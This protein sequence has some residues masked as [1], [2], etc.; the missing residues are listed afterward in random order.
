MDTI[1]EETNRNTRRDVLASVALV[2]AMVISLA[3]SAVVIAHCERCAV[4]IILN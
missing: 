4:P 2:L 3:C 1:H